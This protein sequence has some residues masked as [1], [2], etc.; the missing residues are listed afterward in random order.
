MRTL[1][2]RPDRFEYNIWGCQ[3]GIRFPIVKIL[4]YHYHRLIVV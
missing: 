3:A 1:S 2:W 4:D